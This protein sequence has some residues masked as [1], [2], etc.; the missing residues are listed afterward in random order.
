MDNLS[1]ISNEISLSNIEHY[2]DKLSSAE[3]QKLCELA[4]IARSASLF[5]KEQL[6]YGLNFYESLCVLSE[7]LSLEHGERNFTERTLDDHFSAYSRIG[8]IFDKSVFSRLLYDYLLDNNILAVERAFFGCAPKDET[9]VYV[10]NAFSDEAFDVFSQEFADPRVRYASSFKESLRLVAD[11][12]VAFCLLPLE[13]RGV[14]IPSVEE[15]VFR[16]D[17]KINSVI[18]VFGYDG[19]AE[20]KYALVSKNLFPSD[21]SADDDRYF[22]IRIP[23]DLDNALASIAVLS[24]EFGVRVHRFNTVSLTVENTESTYFSV[25]FKTVG[26]DFTRLLIYFTLFM[27][28]HIP[29]G[30][31]KNI[32]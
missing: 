21:F 16:G 17:F 14:R 5:I 12:L 32:E 7:T 8:S 9:F 4:E 2:Y 23:T 1:F 19:N 28:E 29:V 6:N 3:E 15:L 18:P 25:V 30:I 20:M 27:P 11:D 22:E 31:Y 10:K 24:E 13:E 26:A